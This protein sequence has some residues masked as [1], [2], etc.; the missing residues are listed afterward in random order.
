MIAMWEATFVLQLV[1]WA[2]LIWPREKK[3]SAL[4]RGLWRTIGAVQIIIGVAIILRPTQ[5]LGLDAGTAV[6]VGA[7]VYTLA[8]R[9][10]APGANCGCLGRVGLQDELIGPP[11]LLVAGFASAAAGKMFESSRMEI[12]GRILLLTSM[13]LIGIVALHLGYTLLQASRLHGAEPSVILATTFKRRRPQGD[14][15][16]MQVLKLKRG[17]FSW[18]VTYLALRG[19]SVA[20]ITRRKWWIG[21]G[22]SHT[23]R[24]II[25]I[26]EKV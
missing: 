20:E 4:W 7:S 14:E 10:T 19:N 16:L 8:R 12:V 25:K 23:T 11:F 2:K 24:A 13:G 22:E 18:K 3:N 15:P 26:M 17:W 21:A 6:F 9:R 1:G 5:L